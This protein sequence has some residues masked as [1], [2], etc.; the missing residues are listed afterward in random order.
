MN[1]TTAQKDDSA[2]R[3]LVPTKVRF[4]VQSRRP[5]KAQG[6]QVKDTSYSQLP[7]HTRIVEVRTLR[8]FRRLWREL[9]RVIESGEWRDVRRLAAASE[10]PAAGSPLAADRT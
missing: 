7:G 9:E 8:E 10:L 1:N 2:I 3:D 5:Q 4:V 6:G